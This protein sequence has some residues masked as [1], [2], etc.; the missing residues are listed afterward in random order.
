MFLPGLRVERFAVLGILGGFGGVQGVGF[1]LSALRAPGWRLKQK[2]QGP[3]DGG[4][5]SII[6]TL[7]VLGLRAKGFS[8]KCSRI[9][10]L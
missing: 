5:I 10:T 3:A 7:M 8:R 6:G 2:G 1:G 4:L 9:E